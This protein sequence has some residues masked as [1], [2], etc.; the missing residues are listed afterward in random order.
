MPCRPS[1]PST[2][3]CSVVDTAAT[4]EL[5]EA[6]GDAFEGVLFAGCSFPRPDG[7]V[8]DVEAARDRRPRSSPI[9]PNHG[10]TR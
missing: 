4:P 10:N 3:A 1:T 5:I 7:F 9:V 2:T 8:A 6:A